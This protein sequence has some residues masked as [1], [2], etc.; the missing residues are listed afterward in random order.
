MRLVN[1]STTELRFDGIPSFDNDAHHQ[2]RIDIPISEMVGLIALLGRDA[3]ER[4]AKAL[5][6]TLRNHIPELVRLLA[7]ATGMTP[8]ALPPVD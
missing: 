8:P 3:D 1:D 2:Y 6:Q 4:H 7:F 5:Q